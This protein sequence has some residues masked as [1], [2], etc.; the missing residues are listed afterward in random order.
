MGSAA[1]KQPFINPAK[2]GIKKLPG[3]TPWG[4][5][6][7]WDSAEEFPFASTVEGG[8]G[9]AQSISPAFDE[10]SR[11]ANAMVHYSAYLIPVNL[12]SQESQKTTLSSFYS[13]KENGIKQFDLAK[14]G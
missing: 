5:N 1:G 9:Y 12:N 10:L 7:A 3:P 6:Q 13:R 2:Y 11:F 14:K 8:K 4:L